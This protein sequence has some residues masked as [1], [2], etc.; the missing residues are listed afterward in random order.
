MVVFKRGNYYS[1]DFSKLMDFISLT[2]LIGPPGMWLTAY[3]EIK[4]TYH[5][6]G[7]IH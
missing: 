7:L 2:E 4:E 6:G 5:I 1:F 3:V